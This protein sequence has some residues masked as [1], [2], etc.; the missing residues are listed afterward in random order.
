MRKFPCTKCG[1]CCTNILLSEQT[2]FLNR[3][4]GVCRHF[5]EEQ[6]LC[7]IYETRPKICRINIQYESNY[8]KIYSW[9]EFVEVNIQACEILQKTTNNIPNWNIRSYN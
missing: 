7:S 2:S 5:N 1:K 4:D 8:K 9:D 6:S 3:G